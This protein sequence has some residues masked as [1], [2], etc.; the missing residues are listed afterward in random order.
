MVLSSEVQGEGWT[1]LHPE[2][3]SVEIKHIEARPAAQT[4][5]HHVDG[6]RPWSLSGDIIANLPNF[7]NFKISTHHPHPTSPTQLQSINIIKMFAVMKD[8]ESDKEM[9]PIEGSADDNGMGAPLL[10]SRLGFVLRSQG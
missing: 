7:C 1:N 4:A 6:L 9:K 10:S 8:S 3:I 2:A 5:Q